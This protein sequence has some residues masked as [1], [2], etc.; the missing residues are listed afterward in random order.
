MPMTP[1]TPTESPP[2]YEFLAPPPT[3]RPLRPVRSA[4]N[5]AGAHAPRQS[6][7]VDPRGNL[8]V[9]FVVDEL[10]SPTFSSPRPS[11]EIRRVKSSSALSVATSTQDS[12]PKDQ[13][14]WKAALGEAQYFAGGLIS[15]PAESTKHFTII[16][17]SN[18]LVWYRGPATSIPITILSDAPLPHDRSVW[19]QQKGF[20]GNMGMTLKALVGTTGNW[21]NV[22]PATEAR[23]EHLPEPE[24]RGIQRDLKRFFK[25]ASGRL[26]THTPRETH[27][28]RIPA[29]AQDGYFRLVLGSGDE[30]KKVLCGSPVFRIAS[31]TTD[32]SAVRGASL[33]TMP[34]EMGVKVGTTIAQQVARKYTGIAGAVV[35]SRAVKFVPN[36]AFKKVANAA[37]HTSGLGDAVNESWRNGKAGRYDPLTGGPALDGPLCVVGADTGPEAPF[38]FKFSGKVVRGTGLST[39]ELGI[40]TA[41]VGDVADE[42]K[43]RM[44]GVFAAWARV[45]PD[46]KTEDIDD[47]WHEAVVTIAPLRNAPPGVVL[48][49]KVAVHIIHDFDNAVFFDARVKVM[50][51]GYL[52]PWT[53]SQ[54]DQ[55]IVA[56]HSQDIMI[57]AASLG[58]DNWEP[59]ETASKM[60]NLRSERSFSDRLNEATSRVQGQ[61]DRLPAHW[62]G[63]R[64]EAGTM[65]DGVYGNGGLWIRR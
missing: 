63:V 22:T 27:V 18:A 48:R 40:P 26:K 34:I 29:S 5:L 55:D 23:P 7:L 50:L 11:H 28:V 33:S 20:S 12:K 47:D 51:M 45:V 62:M 10:P 44:G 30:G 6:G 52:H 13:S 35:Q 58:R 37:Y 56:E 42:V 1:P 2:A 16:R 24:E 49:N 25:K 41:N 31:T 36:A 53:P 57:T 64:S 39:R 59:I 32:V 9:G 19:L 46:N 15:H 60:R 17:H 14:K 4:T 8:P 21:I 54:T 43:M 38:P 3:R 61:V 65:R